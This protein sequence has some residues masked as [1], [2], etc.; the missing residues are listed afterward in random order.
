VVAG[1]AFDNSK[2]QCQLRILVGRADHGRTWPVSSLRWRVENKLTVI[3][4]CTGRGSHR[5]E[6][7][8]RRLRVEGT[9]LQVAPQAKRECEEVWIAQSS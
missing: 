4:T 8:R 1:A 5:K 9:P 3:S 6:L 2:S 7:E